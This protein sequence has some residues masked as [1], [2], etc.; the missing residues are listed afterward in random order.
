VPTSRQI[1]TAG[2]LLGGGGPLTGNLNLTLGAA[3]GAEILAGT[4]NNVVMTP[5]GYAA[6]FS[7]SGDVLVLP[8][9][10]MMM[11][12][13]IAGS[14]AEGSVFATLPSSFTT[15]DYGLSITAINQSANNNRDV[16]A[17][18]V[19]KSVSGFTA[20]LNYDGSG[21]NSI[22]GFDYIAIGR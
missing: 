2:P 3:T 17:Q 10:W 5:A 21:T 19:S 20:Y 13:S 9:G 14:Y 16:F 12:G 1:N 8:G 15:A 7:G 22:D 18:R 11:K 6:A 4:A